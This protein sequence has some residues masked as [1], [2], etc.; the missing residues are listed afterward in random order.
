MVGLKAKMFAGRITAP[1][2]KTL[3]FKAVSNDFIKSHVVWSPQIDFT[4]VFEKLP[5]K[6][7]EIC[8]LMIF[9][10]RGCH[11]VGAGGMKQHVAVGFFDNNKHDQKC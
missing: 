10:R 6:P 9:I 7:Q 4:V 5:R 11:R 1:K 8:Y 3:H 2:K